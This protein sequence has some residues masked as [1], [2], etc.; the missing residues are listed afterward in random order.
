MRMT[1]IAKYQ[2]LRTNH[3]GK[4]NTPGMVSYSNFAT[5]AG[6]QKLINQFLG[7]NPGA[8]KNCQFWV[9]TEYVDD[10]FKYVKE[11]Y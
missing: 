3:V 5:A 10:D 9:D 2:N 1:Y 6:A 8:K 4:L 7:E 11:R